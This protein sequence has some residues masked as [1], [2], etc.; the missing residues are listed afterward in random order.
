MPTAGLDVDKLLNELEAARNLF[1]SGNASRIAKLLTQ[2]SKFQFTDP[3]Q[4]IRFHECLLFLRAFPHTRSINSRVENLLNTFHQRI[5]KLRAANADMPLFDDF[6]T[7]GIAGTTMQDT[8]S[9]DVVQWLVRRIPDNVEIAWNDYWDNYETERARGSIWPRFIPMLEEDADVEANI[10]WRNW[11]EAA[12]GRENP[13]QW[14]V[15]CFEQ[16]PLPPR[17]RAELY[18]SLHLPVRWRLENLKLSRTRN[19]VS[20]RR[21]YFHD[22]PLIRRSEVSLAVEL[23]RAAPKFQKLS[24]AAGESVMNAIR[25]VML[26]RYRE[27]YGTTLGD[28]RTVVRADL[29]RGVVMHFWGLPVD[30]RLPLRAYLAGY[31]L[32]NGVPINYVE[33]IGLCEWIEVGFNTFYT[34]RQGETAWIYAQALRCLYALTAAKWVSIYPYQIGQ[35]NDE[36]IDSGAFW[37]YRKLGFRP[38]RAD[39]QQLC[40]RE[41]EKIAGNREYKTPSRILRRLAEAHML[42]DV[43]PSARGQQPGPWD[44]FSTR[45]LGLLINRRMARQFDGDNRRIR[46]ASTTAITRI[47]KLDLTRWSPTQIQSLE[48]WSL[49]LA[50]IPDLSRWS[51]AEKDQ[52]VKIIRAKT[53]ANEMTYL[54]Q[55]QRHARLR[56]ALLRL[57]L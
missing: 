36:A 17:Q 51:L 30:R 29:G 23:A 11:L 10:P 9:F 28:P 5:K 22:A 42:Y 24:A 19:W 21:F 34:Y 38:G 3:R 41:E 44:T 33:A 37:F 50:L 43:H 46:K 1:D 57:G 56:A 39:L 16:L 8:L 25:E 20:P 35:N 55:T 27:L 2:L 53:A 4:L 15:Q 54:R 45:N 40:E 32:K 13:L 6:D 48:N 18:D 52:L 31:T 47:L 26:V 7:S 14:L 49:I 12:R